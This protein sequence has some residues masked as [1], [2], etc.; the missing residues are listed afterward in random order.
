VL[1]PAFA[2]IL[3]SEIRIM[4]DFAANAISSLSNVDPNYISD[5]LSGSVNQPFTPPLDC[6]TNNLVTMRNKISNLRK[7]FVPQMQLLAVPSSGI[8]T[9]IKV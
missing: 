8:L 1:A 6:I 3:I 7:S 2:T 9:G 5:I 4:L